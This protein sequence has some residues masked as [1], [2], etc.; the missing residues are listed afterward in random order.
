[1]V[2]L[3]SGCQSTGSSHTRV[4]VSFD[5][6]DKERQAETQ[7]IVGFVDDCHTTMAVNAAKQTILDF[8]NRQEG[9]FGERS[10]RVLV[11]GFVVRVP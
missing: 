9:G 5:K 4:I 10:G 1:M 11:S 8:F 2:F 6:F 3:Y 7:L